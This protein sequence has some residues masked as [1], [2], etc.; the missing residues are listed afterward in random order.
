VKLFIIGCLKDLFEVI[1]DHREFEIV[2]RMAQGL[3]DL[4]F[5]SLI[6]KDLNY[7]FQGSQLR[8]LEKSS[9]F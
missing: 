4:D 5:S 6:L 7:F 1:Y 2:F 8:F 3:L 9:K